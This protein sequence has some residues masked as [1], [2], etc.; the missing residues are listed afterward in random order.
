VSFLG[1][2]LSSEQIAPGDEMVLTTA[3]QVTARPEAPPLSIFAHLVG[4]TGAVSVGDGL[5]FPAIQWVPGDVFIQRNRLLIPAE[6]PP[7]RYWVQ[8]GLYSLATDERLPVRKASK[9]VADRLLLA[10]VTV[11]D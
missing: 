3:W 1:Y 4:P 2:G 8:V 9:P 5:G 10:P 11:G 6:A 7:G